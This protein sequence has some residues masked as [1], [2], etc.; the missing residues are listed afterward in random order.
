MSLGK[1]GQ[2]IVMPANYGSR[3]S[4]AFRPT[5]SN[6]SGTKT[7]SYKVDQDDFA[8]F[9][10]REFGLTKQQIALT[11]EAK[12]LGK[13]SITTLVND[14]FNTIKTN[15]GK[16]HEFFSSALNRY[17]NAGYPEDEAND[18][19]FRAIKSLVKDAVNAAEMSHPLDAFKTKMENA[20]LT[21]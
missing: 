16:L 10:M 2:K 6:V 5:V 1:V 4:R 7:I 20:T 8:N 9:I 13:A 18:L 17:V 11:A 19:A 21:I 14:H 12:T 15:I 3:S